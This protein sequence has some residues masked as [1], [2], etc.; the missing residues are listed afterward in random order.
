[1][2]PAPSIT[3]SPAKPIATPAMCRALMRSSVVSTWAISAVNSGLVAISTAAKAVGMNGAAMAISTKGP[4]SLNADMTAKPLQA[5]RV[6]GSRRPAAR[7]SGIAASTTFAAT[8]VKGGSSHP[9]MLSANRLPPQSTES[10][11]SRPHSPA[12]MRRITSVSPGLARDVCS[13]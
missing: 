4:A 9:A 7:V 11:S 12:V 10:T 8:M 2:P 1:M 6:K 3:A 5:R 13:L